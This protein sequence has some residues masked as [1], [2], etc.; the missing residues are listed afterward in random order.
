M[1]KPDDNNSENGNRAFDRRLLRGPQNG[2]KDLK[3]SIQIG[4]EFFQGFRALR[5]VRNCVT[6]FGSARFT[7]DH[8][9]YQMAEEFAYRLGK[10]GYSIMTGGGPG[11]MEAG[12]RGARR[13]GEAPR[14]R[15]PK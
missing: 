7:E 4:S 3:R 1:T 15:R 13:A 9:Y 5:H 11:I 12:N 2:W 10:E 8:P 6:I 14:S